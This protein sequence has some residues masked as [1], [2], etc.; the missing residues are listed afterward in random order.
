MTWP[1]LKGCSQWPR[2]RA[3]LTEGRA[4]AHGG[5]RTGRRVAGRADPGSV[6]LARDG[7]SIGSVGRL[8]RHVHRRRVVRQDG[9]PGQG[10]IVHL[11]LGG[12]VH[13]RH[14][15]LACTR[16][17]DPDPAGRHRRCRCSRHGRGGRFGRRRTLRGQRGRRCSGRGGRGR[18]FG[19][20]DRTGRSRIHRGGGCPTGLPPNPG[21]LTGDSSVGE[22]AECRVAGAVGLATPSTV[23]VTTAANTVPQAAT[24]QYRSAGPAVSGGPGCG[25]TPSDPGAPAESAGGSSTAG[26]P[27]RSLYG[28]AAHEGLRAGQVENVW[29]PPSVV[30]RLFEATT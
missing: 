1:A 13:D 24:H 29:S 6:D 12:S 25:S 17:L 2:P 8:G 14:R 21:S 19:G 4:A 28:R 11:R 20:G 30:P 23:A 26:R 10:Y 7:R 9:R 18:G 15:S 27:G 22:R 16:D 3:S 5:E